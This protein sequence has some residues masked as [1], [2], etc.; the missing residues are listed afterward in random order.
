MDALWTGTWGAATGSEEGKV[1]GSEH[2]I[3][4][5]KIPPGK[6]VWRQNPETGERELCW[7]SLEDDSK[8]APVPGSRGKHATAA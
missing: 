6:F 4:P 1:T 8:P 7:C 5:G 2:P 3:P